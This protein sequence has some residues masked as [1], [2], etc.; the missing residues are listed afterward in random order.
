MKKR[1]TLLLSLIL[2]GIGCIHA[3][4]PVKGVFVTANGMKISYLFSQVPTITYTDGTGGIRIAQLTIQGEE[5]PVVTVELKDGAKLTVI[6]GE[7]IPTEIEETA[8]STNPIVEK[9]GRKYISAGRLVI[10]SA[11]GKKYN[12]SGAEI[13]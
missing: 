2:I 8:A 5:V 13:K 4:D 11:D 12:V 10:I 6:Y 3:Q 7:F 1:F 9:A